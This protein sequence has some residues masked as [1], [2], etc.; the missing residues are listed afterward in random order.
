[1]LM[2]KKN[3]HFSRSIMKEFILRNI[4]IIR[5]KTR[6]IIPHDD[7]SQGLHLSHN[8]ALSMLASFESIDLLPICSPSFIVLCLLFIDF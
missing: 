7:A 8:Y 1:M 4:C 5:T 3:L 2:L 6:F